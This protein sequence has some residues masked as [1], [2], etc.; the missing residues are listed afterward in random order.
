MPKCTQCDNEE[1]LWR[2]H[3]G[4]L[5]CQACTQCEHEDSCYLNH[6]C[7]DCLRDVHTLWTFRGPRIRDLETYREAALREYGIGG[8]LLLYWTEQEEALAWLGLD[9]EHDGTRPRLGP[10]R[11]LPPHLRLRALARRNALPEI[12]SGT[13]TSP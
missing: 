10:V 8:S 4:A 5:L 3:T 1:D 6:V 9:R 12:L 7:L 13:A 11:A 2:W